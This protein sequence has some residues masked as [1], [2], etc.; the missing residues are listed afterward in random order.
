MIMLFLN[1]S[2][3]ELYLLLANQFIFIDIFAD[4]L[5]IHEGLRPSGAKSLRLYANL[6]Y[7]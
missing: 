4:Y 7:R 5:A 6:L 1:D 2:K 3:Y